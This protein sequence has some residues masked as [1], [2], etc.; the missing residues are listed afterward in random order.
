MKSKY[1]N[2]TVKYCNLEAKFR[3][4]TISSQ[5]IDEKNSE[6]EAEIRKLKNQMME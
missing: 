2:H 4:L 5:A 3:Q 1:V 6:L